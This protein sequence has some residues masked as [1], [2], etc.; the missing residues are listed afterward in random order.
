MDKIAGQINFFPPG[1]KFVGPGN[2]GNFALGPS[3]AVTLFARV[4][5]ITIG[6]ITFIAIIWFIYKLIIGAVG[7]ISSGGDKAKLQ[8]AKEELTYGIIG[9]V[10]VIAGVFLADLI[11]SL[12]GV[13]ILNVAGTILNLTP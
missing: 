9:L 8:Q 13:P 10:V 7:I 6:V 4:I 12:L 11:G 3:V 1:K 5:S 2:L